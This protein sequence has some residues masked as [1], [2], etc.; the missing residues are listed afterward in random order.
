MYQELQ[1]LLSVSISKNEFHF[2]LIKQI[3]IYLRLVLF[4]P[5][6]LLCWKLTQ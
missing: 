2:A 5:A 1:E 3:F 6:I 4:L